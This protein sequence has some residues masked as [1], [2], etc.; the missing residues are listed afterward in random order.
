MKGQMPEPTSQEPA[1]PPASAGSSSRFLVNVLW[2]WLGV[3]VSLFIGFVLSPVVVHRLG[4]ERYGIWALVFSLLDYFWFFDLGVNT[5]IV[6]FSARFQASGRPDKINQLLNTALSFFSV[7]SVTLAGLSWLVSSNSAWLFPNVSP[8]YRP[9]FAHLILLT[10]VSWGGF[11][12]LH[13]FTSCLDG[14]QRFD[15]TSRAWITMLLFRGIG[16][17]TVLLMGYGL[18]EMAVVVVLG[19]LLCYLL[20]FWNLRRI[21]PELRFSRSL[22]SWAMLKE[23]AGYGV[24]S[25]VA[26]SATLLLNQGPPVVI[27]HFLPVAAV[28]FFT[29]PSRL[30]QYGVDAV[31]RVGLVTRSRTAVLDASQDHESV[32]RLGVYTNRYCFAMFMP[33][34]IF[35]MLYADE[36][37]RL[38]MNAT[39]AVQGAPVLRILAPTIAL[40]MAGQFNSSSILFGL[41]R[42][43]PYARVM[44]AEAV[45]SVALLWLVVPTHGILG[46]AVVTSSLMLVSRGM[47]TPWIVCRGLGVPLVSYMRSIYLAPLL[48]A[49]PVLA[50]AWFLKLHGLPGRNWRELVTAAAL[51]SVL[52]LAGALMTT[53]EPEHRLLLWTWVRRLQKTAA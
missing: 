35:L 18:M 53:F 15:L 32:F 22:V 21:F 41:N 37:L 10:G 52:Y 43:R 50:V 28:G 26:N 3:A 4:E 25:F 11:V 33:A 8:Q 19:Q 36:A 23:M 6:N 42:H 46:A 7:I 14:F 12:L 31:S 27:G 30:L 34:V 16:S 40:V 29:L 49:A 51:V 45:I 1:T 2:N 17:M 13:I 47:I 39:F 44:L 24:H 5:A 9:E 38:W 20:N 48:T